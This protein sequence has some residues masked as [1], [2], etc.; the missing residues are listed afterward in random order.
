VSTPRVVPAA[1]PF[2]GFVK[3]LGRGK[4]ARRSLTEAEAEEAFAMILRGEATAAQTGAFLMLLRV[5]EETPEEITG[6]VRAA[7]A[8]C[9]HPA[10]VISVDLDWPSYSGK[11][12][13]QPW[14]LLAALLL[15][16]AGIRVLMHGCAPHAQDRLFA[17][18]ALGALGITPDA[19]WEQ[20]A[21]SLQLRNFSYLALHT[22]APELQQLLDM[23]AEF[24][25]RSPVNTLL[26]HLDPAGARAGLRSL[27]HPAYARLHVE[28]AVALGNRNVA[29]FRGEGGECELRAD[30]DTPLA[31]VREGG[32]QDITLSRTLAQ[33]SVKPD[34][35]CATA[36]RGLWNEIAPCV[37]GLES[38]LGTAGVGLLALGHATDI[39]AARVMARAMWR[40]RGALPEC[41][42]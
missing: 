25:L 16:S 7:R 34:A 2:A 41:S 12:Q 38:V 9:A 13:H 24:G 20:A 4:T 32:T 14:Y 6:M 22:L 11:R 40:Q 21:R 1:H 19:S 33:R 17:V 18:D 15:A 29:V 31:L 42:A 3:L 30:A 27:H 39:D 35:L 36:L 23:R 28:S 37:Y 10:A 8:H 5:K 26:R